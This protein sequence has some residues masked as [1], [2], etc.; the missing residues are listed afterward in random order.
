VILENEF[1]AGLKLAAFLGGGS[2]SRLEIRPRRGQFA[3]CEIRYFSHRNIILCD[4]AVNVERILKFAKN[5]Q[6]ITF[7]EIQEP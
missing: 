4:D 7:G 3:R 6:T 2:I 5:F 1:H